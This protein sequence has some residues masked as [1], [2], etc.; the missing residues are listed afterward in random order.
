MKLAVTIN[1][2]D[3][4]ELLETVL[5][6]IRSEVDWIIA[7]YQEK[8]YFGKPMADE[9][10]IEINR[11]KEIGLIDEL[12][13]YTPDSKLYSREQECEKRRASVIYAQKKGYTHILNMDEDEY[14][15]TQQFI[16][17]KKLIKEKNL[18]TTYVSYINYFRDTSH[19]TKM[20]FRPLVSFIHRTYFNYRY[21]GGAPGPTD[22]TRRLDNPLGLGEYVFT[23]DEIFMHH[24]SMVRSNIRKKLNNW[25]AKN[26]FPDS[27]IEK[28]AQSYENFKDDGNGALMLFNVPDN[29][30]KIKKLD[31]PFIELQLDW[32]TPV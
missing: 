24:L 4:S 8:S 30:V 15:I 27:L 9:D 28:V 16:D 25:S 13:C 12:M 6:Q 3:A 21:N 11:L 20:P 26:H 1:C 32:I 22:P 23:N 2:F 29:T 17:A 10:K 31:K 5:N 7:V 19:H 14:Y 18:N